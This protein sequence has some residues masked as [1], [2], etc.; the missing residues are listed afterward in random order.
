MTKEKDPAA[1]GNSMK[2]MDIDCGIFCEE[3]ND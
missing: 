1:T 2:T 3:R